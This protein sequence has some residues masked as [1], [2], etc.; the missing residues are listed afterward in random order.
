MDP[1]PGTPS[2][3]GQDHVRSMCF[4]AAR[5]GGGRPEARVGTHA[6]TAGRGVAARRW[7]SEVPRGEWIATS[8]TPP[9]VL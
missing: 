3:K 9:F 4:A 5:P 7:M 8:R 6:Q 2:G 1:S